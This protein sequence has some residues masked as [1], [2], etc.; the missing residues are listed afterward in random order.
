M[1]MGKKSRAQQLEAYTCFLH[2]HTENINLL[3]K[4]A[5]FQKTRKI[6]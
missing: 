3:F 5:A 6:T 1:F 4:S 2:D